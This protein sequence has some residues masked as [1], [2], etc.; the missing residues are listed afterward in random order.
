MGQHTG[1]HLPPPPLPLL[2]LPL[3]HPGTKTQPPPPN[4]CTLGPPYPS[5][6]VW[7]PATHH[8]T[9]WQ[10]VASKPPFPGTLVGVPTVL[11]PPPSPFPAPSTRPAHHPSLCTPHAPRQT[12]LL[13]STSAGDLTVLS[14]PHLPPST[15]AGNPTELSLPHLPPSTSGGD[16]AVLSLPPSPAIPFTPPGPFFPQVVVVS[17]PGR[18]GRTPRRRHGDPGPCKFPVGGPTFSNPPFPPVQ[19]NGRPHGC[20][21][22]PNPPLPCTNPIPLA[23]PTGRRPCGPAVTQRATV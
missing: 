9:R 17:Y 5:P 20:T 12:L 23:L 19:R 16:P 3:L 18:R 14:L 10:I 13:P 21:G 4:P 2:P 11:S 7:P 8:A 15:S 22:K 1:M 6:A